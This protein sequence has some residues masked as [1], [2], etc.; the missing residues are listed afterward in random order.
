MIL[1]E[2]LNVRVGQ[3]MGLFLREGRENRHLGSS[4]SK[5]LNGLMDYVDTQ[6][7]TLHPERIRGVGFLPLLEQLL[8]HNFD[9]LNQQK[10]FQ[11]IISLFCMH[12]LK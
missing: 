3:L 2:E 4:R 6:L 11:V 1:V 8:L 7:Q 5:I 9:P 12:P 10:L